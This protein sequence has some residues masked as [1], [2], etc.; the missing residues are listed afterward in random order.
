MSIW[1]WIIIY[2]IISVCFLMLIHKHIPIK[3]RKISKL[4]I[5][6]VLP[7]MPIIFVVSFI[8]GSIKTLKGESND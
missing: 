2:L 4:S 5:L 8:V 3:K 1:S 7:F 6:I